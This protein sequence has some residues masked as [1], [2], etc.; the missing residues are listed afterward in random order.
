[1]QQNSIFT[2]VI[3]GSI[4]P[5]AAYLM[6]TYTSFQQQF[7]AEKPIALYVIA[8]VI[9]LIIV[10]FAYRGGKESLAKGIVLITFVAMLVLIFVTKLKVG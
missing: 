10:R 9:N 8:T 7:F 4:A 5:L 1:M 2:G 3:L 6:M